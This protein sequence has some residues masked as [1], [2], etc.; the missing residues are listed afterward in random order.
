M[1]VRYNQDKG[2]TPGDLTESDLHKHRTKQNKGKVSSCIC[3]I[4]YRHKAFKHLGGRNHLHELQQI[5]EDIE[6]SHCQAM[7][8]EDGTCPCKIQTKNPIY[9]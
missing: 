6:V 7:H 3:D 5:C 9:N 8:L 2:T 1:S 4:Q